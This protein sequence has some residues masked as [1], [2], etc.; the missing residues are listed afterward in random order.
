MTPN[1][2]IEISATREDKSEAV[3]TW[4][5]FYPEAIY[6]LIGRVVPGVVVVT[7]ILQGVGNRFPV[8]LPLPS[9][10]IQ[11]L[12]VILGFLFGLIG[13]AW[14]MRHLTAYW[15]GFT[16]RNIL[17]GIMSIIST[18]RSGRCW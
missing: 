4:A 15:L 14:Q 11:I 2:D 7:A 10:G 8:P 12:I 1:G 17:S 16:A 6:D 5:R 3:A 13:D 18:L 9:W